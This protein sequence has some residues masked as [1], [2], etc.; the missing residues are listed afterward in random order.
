MIS[1]NP[2]RGGKGVLSAQMQG[3]KHDN[4]TK[5]SSKHLVSEKLIPASSGP[6]LICRVVDTLF[7]LLVIS[8]ALFLVVAWLR[9]QN[10]AFGAAAMSTTQNRFFCRLF[11]PKN[12]EGD[13]HFSS[14]S[15]IPNLVGYTLGRT[16]SPPY[17]GLSSFS[18][19]S[20]LY[21]FASESVPSSHSLFSYLI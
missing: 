11:L 21:Y 12:A 3:T 6:D 9:C 19:H 1:A 16:T 18:L 5:A 13:G 10:E 2:T 15:S 7:L 8:L 17:H 4:F 14:S 20:L